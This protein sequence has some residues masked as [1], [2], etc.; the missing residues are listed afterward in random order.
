[1]RLSINTREV[2]GVTVLDLSGR[3]IFGEECSTL[4]KLI[5]DLVTNG[6]SKLLLNLADVTYLDSTGVGILVESV[7]ASS[8]QG[9]H[10][11][12]VNLGRAVRETLALQRL[13]PVFEV[14]VNEEEALAS[15][16]TEG[17]EVRSIEQLVLSN[18]STLEALVGLVDKE[19]LISMEE[20]L[21][22]REKIRRK[23]MPD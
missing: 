17:D 15:F 1:M 10:L 22:R 23:A 5:Q 3:V 2:S 11:K 16:A 12:L 9:W 13:L 6:K 7:I 8:K 14:Y 18:R 21:E 4:R 19:G 20:L